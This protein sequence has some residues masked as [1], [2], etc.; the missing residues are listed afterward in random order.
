MIFVRKT[1][2]LVLFKTWRKKKQPKTITTALLMETAVLL[3][4][5]ANKAKWKWCQNIFALFKDMFMIIT[6]YAWLNCFCNIPSKTVSGVFFWCKA[7]KDCLVCSKTIHHQTRQWPQALFQHRLLRLG[8][9]GT[10][11]G[12]RGPQA[13]FSDRKGHQVQGLSGLH[14]DIS[15]VASGICCI[16]VIG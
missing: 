3:Y 6:I 5:S 9:A 1:F 12:Y 14:T 4:F 16:N 15:T 2:E 11:L 10:V 8:L 13:V 7:R